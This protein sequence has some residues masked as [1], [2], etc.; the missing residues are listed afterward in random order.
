MENIVVTEEK[1]SFYITKS[2]KLN[3]SD[4][5]RQTR[6]A[7]LSNFT[8]DGLVETIKVKCGELNVVCDTF[9]GGYN[10]Y[11]EE[12]L[13]NKSNLY[14]FSPDLCFLILDIRNIFG[15]LFYSPYNLSVE[16]RKEFIQNK[17]NELVDLAKSFVEKSNS[18]LVVS[19]FVIPTYSSYGIFENKVDY[20]LQEMVFDLN[21]KLSNA[22]KNENSIYLYDLNGFVSRFGQN[23]VFD[24]KQYFFGDIKISLNYIPFLANDLL[25][26][27]KP[28]LGLNKKCIVLDLDNT[29]WGGIV[30]EDGFNGI[31]LSQ[32]D[33]IGK[34]F[35]EFQKY[36]LSLHERGII[37]AVNSR[38]NS[39]DAMQ[40]IKEHPD[41]V[42]REKH[43]ACLKI[44]WNDKVTNL[45]EIA[46]ELNIGIDS[47]LFMDDDNVNR[48]FMREALPEVLT[49]ELPNDPSL[50]TQTLMELNEFNILKITDEDKKRGKMY[51][52]QKE[53]IE[54]EKSSINFEE[55]LKQL[56][57]K[58][59]IKKAD[60]FT[61]PRISQLT[62]K[63]NQF[64]LTT[65]RYQEEE[66]IRF[67][68]DKKK[69]V[70]C[71]RIEDKFG[72]YGITGAFIVNKDNP[73]EWVMDTFLLSCRV[74]GR[75]VEE[76]I[77]D[78]IVNDAKKNNVKRLIGNFIPTKK[79]KP[80]ESFLQNFGFKKEGNRWI[81]SLE[82]HSKK[83]SHL[84]V[85]GE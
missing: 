60:E 18:K 59:H 34:A 31:K 17:V 19:N 33:P 51:L 81:Y 65:K 79:N 48:D 75:G 68:Q 47:I 21:Y 73:E 10:R 9:Y 41:M 70:G 53:R 83:P 30:G 23:N 27:I 22:W 56:G 61:I 7:L 37:L 62:L 85:L 12:I 44:N 58:I 36:L 11:N 66:I 40:V 16:K 38:N 32:N 46:Q 54:F 2:K 55:Y 84:L 50:Y 25:G 69:I 72:D 71:A 49:V 39:E 80:S 13:N 57:I 24:Y 4:F 6:I 76:G 35:I 67:S 78:Y 52:Q 15:D 45:Q 29:L 3:I 8:L 82:N 26:F 1:L 74:I 28:V 14:S 20:G 63:T 5:K 77:L 42:L 43:F 64:N